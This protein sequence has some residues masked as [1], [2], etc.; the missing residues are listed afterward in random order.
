MCFLGTLF[1]TVIGVLRMR[2]VGTMVVVV[3]Q[4]AFEGLGP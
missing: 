2:D 4:P 3:M 1:K